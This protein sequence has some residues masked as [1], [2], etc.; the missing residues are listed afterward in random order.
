MSQFL[1]HRQLADEMDLI[2]FN[3]QVGAG[4]PL[5]LPRGAALRDALEEFMKR[6]EF[7]EGYQRVY[8]PHVAKAQMYHQSGHLAAFSENMFPPMKWPEDEGEYYLRPMNCPHHHKIFSSKLRSYKEMPLRLCEHGQV[9]RYEN[10][11]SLKGLSRVRGLCQN[12]AHI[13]LSS[14][15]V[16]SE[17]RKV[18]KMHLHCYE[19]LGLKGFRFR[20]S[21]HDPK[22]SQDFHGKL[23]SWVIAENILRELLQEMN[24][25]YFEA[26]GEAA[27]YGPKID[28][29]MKVSN[30]NEESIASVQIDFNSAE[31]FNLFFINENG[32]Q[33]IPWIIHRA[34]LGSHERFVAILLE[35]YQGRLPWW[36]APVQVYF[37]PVN[38]LVASE[39]ENLNWSLRQI[40]LR[41]EVC[42]QDGSLS[43]KI[44]SAHLLRP[45]FQIVYGN[46]EAKSGFLRLQQHKKDDVIVAISELG[47]YLSKLK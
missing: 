47:P 28:V 10:S 24:L 34:P 12:D 7:R 22:S 6:L 5:W 42:R 45:Y 27:F 11:G 25:E 15:E 31:K 44:R 39:V 38:D 43:K 3:E 17:V 21:K 19:V 35:Y 46:E 36:L 8:S 30:G 13:Y 29:Q 26:E 41:S 32:Q 14:K 9:Y 23:E 37:L 40:G 33:E 2:A 1:D 4:L 18:I 20:L 16:K